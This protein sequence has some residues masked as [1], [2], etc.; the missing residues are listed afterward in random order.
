MGD[1][2]D[3]FQMAS[4]P[5]SSANYKKNELGMTDEEM[6]RMLSYFDTKNLATMIKCPTYMNFSLQDNVCPPHTNWAA[7][8][9][10]VSTDK[11]YSVNPTLGHQGP[12]N[13]RNEYSSFFSAHMKEPESIN[14]IQVQP[15]HDNAIYNLWGIRVEGTISTQPK[16][17][18]IQNR[19]KIAKFWPQ[20]HLLSGTC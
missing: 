8:N 19:R 16:G 1:F 20:V 7:F 5:A 3:Y 17:I 10:L 13:W 2:P 11:Q 14:I 9:N 12:A 6:F 4:W 15:I 18:Y